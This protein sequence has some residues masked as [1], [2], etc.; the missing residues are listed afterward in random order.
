V[1]YAEYGGA[2]LL[3]VK[4]VCIITHGR[5]NANAIKNAIRVAADVAAG[6]IN[7]H[8]EAGLAAIP[9]RNTATKLPAAPEAAVAHAID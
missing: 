2:P 8:I 6:N 3:G 7:R 4:G 1:D 9:K 5:S